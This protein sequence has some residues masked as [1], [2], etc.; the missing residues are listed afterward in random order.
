M[1]RRP[2]AL[3]S[4]F[5]SSGEHQAASEE[6]DSQMAAFVDSEMARGVIWPSS[7]AASQPCPDRIE[8]YGGCPPCATNG[9]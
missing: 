5:F 3:Q 6:N 8:S 7:S 1:H 4:F 9:L 2:P